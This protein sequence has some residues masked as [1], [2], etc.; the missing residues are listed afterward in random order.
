LKKKSNTVDLQKIGDFTMTEPNIDIRM[1]QSEG[2][3]SRRELAQ[4]EWRRPDLR[5]LPIA[6]TAHSQSKQ[7]GVQ[8]DGNVNK[9]G[10]IFNLS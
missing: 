2:D 10:D 4:K 3:Q 7:V 5:K 6:A 8:N 9:G 1:R